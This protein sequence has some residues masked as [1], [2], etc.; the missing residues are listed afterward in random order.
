MDII[1]QINESSA[2]IKSK[3]TKTPKIGLILG[4]GLGDYVEKIKNPV[5]IDYEDIPHYQKTSVV[6]H[7]G[8]LVIGEI[9]GVTVAVMQGRYHSYEGHDVSVVVHPTRVLKAIGCE[10]MIVT[11]AAGG[12]N[13]KFSPGDLAAISDHINLSGRNPLVG[14]NID[15]LGV[16]FPDMSN[17]YDPE[18]RQLMNKVAN[19][20]NFKL[21]EG[22]YCCLLGPSYETPAEIKMLSVIG[23]DLVGM[24]TAPEVIAAHHASMRVAGISCIT[25]LAA[26]IS[27]TKLDHSEVKEVANLA[28]KKFSALLTGTIE[29]IGQL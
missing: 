24:S 14:E 20:N 7:Q 18:I 28:N 2:Y 23:A 3:T 27:K 12:I 9:Q 22:V 15:E 6:G 13:P 10:F 8:K 1:N 29:L 5:V 16:R 26:G 21:Q 17:V 19:N 11:N 4:S 25:N